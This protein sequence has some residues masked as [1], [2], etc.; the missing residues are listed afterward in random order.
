[1]NLSEILCF[2]EVIKTYLPSDILA[3]SCTLNKAGLT[4]SEHSMAV[5]KQML[6]YLQFY[7]S[8]MRRFFGEDI[9]QVLVFAA[10]VHDLGKVHPGFQ[11]ALRCQGTKFALRH[12]V[13]SLIALQAFPETSESIWAAPAVA[14]HHKSWQQLKAGQTVYF[15]TQGSPA[16]IHALSELLVPLS[17]EVRETLKLFVEECVKSLGTKDAQENA[18]DDTGLMA[19]MT[20]DW[21]AGALFPALAKVETVTNSFSERRLGFRPK[22]NHAQIRRATVVRGLMLAADHTASAFPELV[23]I[24]HV[25]QSP[26]EVLGFFEWSQNDLK[27]HQ[28]SMCH[29]LGSALLIAPTGTGKTEAGLLWA[30]AQR[31]HGVATGRAIFLLPF[32][33]SMNA[34]A[35]RLRHIFGANSVALIHG[36]SLVNAYH[37]ACAEGLEPHEAYLK[38]KAEENLARL[39]AADIRIF[40]PIQMIKPFLLGKNSEEYLLWYF[41]AQIIVDE[42]HAYDTQVTAMTLVILRYLSENMGAKILFMTATL[43]NHLRQILQTQFSE[44]PEPV[45]PPRAY[46]DTIKR[47]R[48]K[49]LRKD[50]FADDILNRVRRDLQTKSVLIVVN[51]VSRAVRLME[52]LQQRLSLNRGQCQVLHSRFTAGDRAK[53]EQKLL[54]VPGRLL[55]ATQVVEV[56][57]N[58]D[59]DVLYTELAPLEALLQRFGRINRY[60]LKGVADVFVCTEFPEEDSFPELPYQAQHLVAVRQV[61]LNFIQDCPDGI[62]EESD[63]PTLI[64][65]SYPD[66]LRQQLVEEIKVKSESFQRYVVQEYL[67]FGMASL[68]HMRELVD[69]WEKMFDSIEVIPSVFAS[70][71]READNSLEANQYLVPISYS[72][73]YRLQKLGKVNYKDLPGHIVVDVPYDPFYGLMLSTP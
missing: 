37:R 10:L 69:Q 60:G 27:P 66:S 29:I 33:A 17:P 2:N 38:A 52:I 40:S 28:K 56:S 12:E 1:M 43:P 19:S 45:I 51:R 23:K 30:G 62:L 35:K 63:I 64:D 53:I 3:K 42:I 54:A 20:W 15:Q 11:Q 32:R 49:L 61:L 6:E 9:F 47:H 41:G 24:Q 73:L 71:A 55:I 72:Q 31:M 70:K 68:E 44:L 26:E 58:M 8:E 57:L 14:L 36:K 25:F 5:A 21:S 18:S 34:M 50:V 16:E 46:L 22:P 13:L 7:E 67:P 59:F 48:L 4:L 65:S 39:N